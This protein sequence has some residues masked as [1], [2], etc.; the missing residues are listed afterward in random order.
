M[1]YQKKQNWIMYPMQQSNTYKFANSPL[2]AFQKDLSGPSIA[3]C[4]DFTQFGCWTCIF[5]EKKT[6]MQPPPNNTIGN[7]PVS[8]KATWKWTMPSSLNKARLICSWEK[9]EEKDDQLFY[10]WRIRPHLARWP[11]LTVTG[12]KSAPLWCLVVA[13]SPLLRLAGGGK[14]AVIVHLSNHKRRIVLKANTLP[15]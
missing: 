15:L 7:G 5:E 4:S 12:P 2:L 9:K 10:F 1:L 13:I 3:F 8:S 6:W 11:N 14:I